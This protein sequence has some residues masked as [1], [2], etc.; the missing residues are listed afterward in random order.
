MKPASIVHFNNRGLGADAIIISQ[1]KILLGKRASDPYK[2]YWSFFGGFVQWDESVENAMMR[3]V[4][5][6]SDLNVTSYKLF[7]VYS[8]P[9][10][11]PRQAITL[12]YV[13]EAEGEPK[14]GDDIY[15][16][17]WF[18]ISD[19]PKMAFDH[20]NILDDYLGARR[21]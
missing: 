14:A 10:R 18:D 20:K 9:N 3:E 8:Q 7:G 13:V 11:H 4:K 5:E 12:V 16:V 17:K 21:V 1:N 6:E 2:D 15:K 19:L